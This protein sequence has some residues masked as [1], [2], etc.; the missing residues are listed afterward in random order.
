MID[1][2]PFQ[3][4]FRIKILSLM[5]DNVWM[6]RYGDGIIIPEYFER[7][8]EEKLARAIID[9][10]K[11]Y[12]SSPKDPTDLV[13]MSG[14]SFDFVVEIYDTERDYNL[15]A[16]LV[17]KFAKQQAAKLA[18]LESVDD[19]QRGDLDT[20]IERIKK[21]ILVGDNITSPGIDPIAD[22]DIWIHD[23]WT[24]KVPTGW[25]HIDRV[26]EG[27]LDVGE[28]GVILGPPNRGKTMALIN[29][30]YNAASLLAGKNVI[31]FTHELKPNAVAKRYA[32]RMMFKFPQVGDNIE[33]Y[34]DN[35]IDTARKLMP[36]KVRVIG[37]AQR[38]T[39]H[40][41]EAN[42]NRLIAE[43]FEPGI[44]IDDYLDLVEPPKAYN[45]RRYELTAIYE[46]YRTLSATYN[47]PVWTAT[48]G[49]RSSLSKEIVTMADVAEDIGKA[50]TAD[51]I[52]AICQTYEEVQVNQCRLFTAKVRDGKKQML[53][54]AKYYDKSQ[55]IVT[56]GIITLKDRKEEKDV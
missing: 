30:G 38:M 34:A 49:N 29:I 10:R 46:W 51:V 53:F 39:T 11:A 47:C 28:E 48:Q 20:P 33:E 9:Y 37:G 6:S 16:D 24:N 22:V 18:I 44:I 14:C 2:Y 55:S 35:L 8:D 1:I 41:I 32:A 31:H 5:L 36:G 17:I 40:E 13:E 12:K 21:A 43:G 3:R 7:D 26:L 50:N 45:E 54:S 25:W 15:T 42:I 56:T 19:I 52:I 27:G 4:E 23:M